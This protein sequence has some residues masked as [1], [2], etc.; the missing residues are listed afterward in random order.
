MSDSVYEPTSP[1]A[2]DDDFERIEKQ[3]IV[4]VARNGA[5]TS[6]QETEQVEQG[7]EDFEMVNRLG[8]DD[9]TEMVSTDKGVT[10]V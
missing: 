7:S 1:P 2:S 8:S 4:G 5:T 10:G 3:G 9:D 6:E